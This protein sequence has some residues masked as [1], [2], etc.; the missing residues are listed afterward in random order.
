[1]TLHSSRPRARR[2]WGVLIVSVAILLSAMGGAALAV[3]DDGAFELDRNAADDAAAPGD[4]WSL[5]DDGPTDPNS[6]DS[7]DSS[8]F[9]AD[10]R[11]PT[12]FTGG[13]S[14]DDLNTTGWKHKNGSTPDKDELLDAYAARYGDSLYFGADRYS[15]SGDAV[16]GFWFFQQEVTP[17]A[18]G[19]FGPGQHED[20]DI[21]VL[22]DFTNGGG[23]VTIRVF[24]WNGP[25]GGIAG[26]GSINGTLDL[27][28]G[29]TSTPAD[30]VGPPAVPNGDNFC[31]TVNT[32]NTASPWAFQ[33]KASG[34]PANTFPAG[35]FFEGGI[36]LGFLDLGDECFASFLAETR[37]STSVDAVLKDLVGGAFESCESTVTTT[38][39]D[40]N[41]VAKTAIEKGGT[42]YDSALIEGT[43]SN[44]APTG[45]MD[46]FI[47]S[48]TQLTAGACP[49]G[50]TKVN[51][52]GTGALNPPAAV[53]PIANTSNSRSIS[54][55]FTP[56]ST[57][58]WCWRGVYS[59]DNNYP[60]ATDASTG[61]CFNVV[62]ARISVTP[63]VAT[64][65]SGTNHRVDA[66]VE[67]D[68][69]SGFGAAPDGTVVSWSL[70]AN[71]AGAT[72]VADGVD[73]D[74]DLI[75]G[76]DC[77]TAGGT[78][79]CFINIT[80]TSTGTVDIRASATFTVGGVSVTRATTSTGTKTDANK[81][82]VNAQIDLSP[83]TA[84]NSITEN[85][86][87]TATV[88]QDDGL[89][90][91]AG[92]GD[93]ASGYGPVAGTTVT[94]SFSQNAIGATFV[95]GNTCVTGAAGT[96]TITI[97]SS[98]A[99]TVKVHATTTFTI[100]PVPTQE[101][102][103]S[104]DG[105]GLNS[106]D[107]EKTFVAGA[108]TWIKNNNA[109]ARLGGATFQVCRTHTLN[110]VTGVQD[111]T[112]DVCASIVDDTSAP[113]GAST[114]L[115]GPDQ[116]PDAGEF[117]LTDLVL[118]R[119]TVRETAAPAGYVADTTTV[120][121][122]DD[123]TVADPNA[124]ITLAFANNREVLKISG[125]GYTNDATGT[126]TSG[127]VNGTTTYTVN[128]HNYGSS[129]A[130]LTNSSLVV[131]L[132]SGTGTVTCN[133]TGTDGLTK[134][135]AGTVAAGGNLAVA[136]TLTCTYSG[137]SDGA[138]ILATLNVK[139][140]TNGLERAASGSPATIKFTVQGD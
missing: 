49:T 112:T 132:A 116:D 20:G 137:M 62:D 37:S 109:G 16:M 84:T 28:A 14:K 111:D 74:G 18:G 133:G 57:G 105:T 10:G 114:G 77:V 31:A 127:V 29:T 8:T 113:V 25:G 51:G 5:I 4:D 47:C 11:G 3:H 97:T 140:T 119:Y 93:A 56:T 124:T 122:A 61:E 78:G 9:V 100:G 104:T 69:G 48:P 65:E 94:F 76:N 33:A 30:C 22:S 55:A 118:G 89:A 45:T 81:R 91:N 87:I 115:N 71:N 134:V 108:L 24:R 54:A 7:A 2:R 68:I 102:T 27:I 12:I 129:A 19:S 60:P 72:F 23:N 98:T 35:H 117:Q 39:S 123:M 41:G 73:S 90:A 101:V 1:M 80:T 130:N 85:H 66:T 53:T 79:Q 34:S 52:T 6:D 95:G 126:P 36:D 103:R 43:G 26:S 38:P 92:G 58:T 70:H 106:A 46:F 50:G 17:Q 44:N 136:V 67:Q 21:L 64:N 139:S 131:S 125:F 88:Q 99:G 135:I 138:E 42:I 75:T 121:T 128:L 82:F 13:G 86:V 120:R 59:G 110:T 107:A 63:L 83:L 15:N 96:C 40:V 32:T